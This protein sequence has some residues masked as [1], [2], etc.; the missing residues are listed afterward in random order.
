MC[1]ESTTFLI[2]SSESMIKRE[3]FDECLKFL[4]LILL[5]RYTS[6]RRSDYVNIILSN[7]LVGEN[8]F[9][10]N[11]VY[12]ILQPTSQINIDLVRNLHVKMTHIKN[13]KNENYQ[14]VT[15]N[16]FQALVVAGLRLNRYFGKKKHARQIVVFT[17]NLIGLDADDNELN[18]MINELNAQFIF[19]YCQNL[20]FSDNFDQTKWGYILNRTNS[21]KMSLHEILMKA[22]VPTSNIVR[23]IRTFQGQLRLGTCENS[24]SRS[25]SINVDGYPSTKI[26]A[27]LTRKM[28]HKAHGNQFSDIKSVIEYHVNNLQQSNIGEMNDTTIVSKSC[29]RKAFR[30][31]TDFTVLPLNIETEKF[32]QTEPGI[33][34]MGFIDLDTLPRYY[35][36][37]EST[38]ILADLKEQSLVN[39]MAFSALVDVLIKQRKLA[40]V[41]YVQRRNSEIQICVLCPL[42]VNNNNKG[43]QIDSLLSTIRVFVL[44]RLPFAEDERNNNFPKLSKVKFDEQHNIDDKMS[45]FIDSMTISSDS[46][47]VDWCHDSK[48]EVFN[49]YQQSITL[50]SWLD[51]GIKRDK[52]LLEIPT[53]ATTRQHQV[54][55]EYIHQNFILENTRATFKIPD[56]SHFLLDKLQPRYTDQTIK[57]SGTLKDMLGIKLA[58]NQNIGTET[59]CNELSR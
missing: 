50:S 5:Q 36:N 29:V 46:S 59:I 14:T 42:L 28:V 39:Y 56:V 12:E 7:C 43:N 51:S 3:S 54:I 44:N 25:L 8:E 30:C 53:I 2:D 35:L 24:K 49:S 32:Y 21:L 19:V 38:Y 4:E 15:S 31:G 27:Q 48:I 57:L 37:S 55:R 18:V 20:T 6:N 9:N 16:T 17:D 1:D 47:L 13:F 33:D 45:K 11:N 52:F 58:D 26:V 23:P 22:S 34:I 40:I 10:L 41:R